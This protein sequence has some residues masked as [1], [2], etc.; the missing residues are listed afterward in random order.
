MD[1]R[2]DEVFEA[3]WMLYHA[4]FTMDGGSRLVPP[5]SSQATGWGPSMLQEACHTLVYLINRRPVPPS[6]PAPSSPTHTNSTL[7]ENTQPGETPLTKTLRLAETVTLDPAEGVRFNGWLSHVATHNSRNYTENHRDYYKE[8]NGF[9]PREDWYWH[10]VQKTGPQTEVK[11]L[12]KEAKEGDGEKKEKTV[13]EEEGGKTQALTQASDAMSTD[14]P[15]ASDDN[16]SKITSPSPY[17]QLNTDNVDLA[18][19]LKKQ[20]ELETPC[21]GACRCCGCGGE[22]RGCWFCAVEAGEG[23]GEWREWGSEKRMGEGG[24]E[25]RGKRRV[26]EKGD[27]EGDMYM[28]RRGWTELEEKEVKG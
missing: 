13:K 3:L 21:C 26:G 8:D 11:E 24:E 17:Y 19:C 2:L 20:V 27:G 1:R 7:E 25:R 18:L 23:N 14:I 10:P 28:L 9:V 16:A 22:D 5:V 15:P 6:D 12:Q 4:Q